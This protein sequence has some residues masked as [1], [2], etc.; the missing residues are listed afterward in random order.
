MKNY[1]NELFDIQKRW[2]KNCKKV[3][4][5]A[6]KKTDSFSYSIEY[7]SFLISNF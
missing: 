4:I 7:I 1:N 3:K 6:K 5:K 2:K